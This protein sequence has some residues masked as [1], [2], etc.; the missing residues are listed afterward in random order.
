MGPYLG[1]GNTLLPPVRFKPQ[2]LENLVV[3]GGGYF[4]VQNLD[5]LVTSALKTIRCDM[6]YTLKPQIR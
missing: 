6:T 4:T 1:S 5:Q 3:T 2:T